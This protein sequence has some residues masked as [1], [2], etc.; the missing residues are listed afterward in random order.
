M[1]IERLIRIFKPEFNLH[2]SLKFLDLIWV[3]KNLVCSF[4]RGFFK[5]IFFKKSKGIVLVG[6]HVKLLN[7][8]HIS[9]AGNLIVEDYAEI[10]GLSEDGL[11]FGKNVSIGKYAMIRPSDYYGRNIGKGL[12]V[13]DN[14]NIGAHAYVGCSGKITIGNNV[15]ISPRVSFYAENHVYSDL[16]RPMKTQGVEK[17]EISVGDDCWI[18]SNSIILSNVKI[19]KGVIVAAGSV[20]NKDIPDYAIVGGVPAKIIKYRK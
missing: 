10:Q 1:V 15:M 7:P 2:P 20:V 18:A 4:F 11:K 19:G 17:G 5:K 9:S 13:G 8:W 6:K 3:L 12:V 16:T 14:S